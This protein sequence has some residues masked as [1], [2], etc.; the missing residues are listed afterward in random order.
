M[1]WA[2]TLISIQVNERVSNTVDELLRCVDG[3]LKVLIIWTAH[4]LHL[5]RVSTLNDALKL[6]LSIPLCSPVSRTLFSRA[7]IAISCFRACLINSIDDMDVCEIFTVTFFLSF[8]CFR[9]YFE[10]IRATAWWIHHLSTP[11]LDTKA[12][13]KK[14][15]I[16]MW[17]L[18]K[19]TN[20][21]SHM[22]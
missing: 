8:F 6:A 20:S 3:K 11:R 2:H 21:T 15:E 22:E 5:L 9:Q 16:K 13:W 12:R 14:S 1:G 10:L 19:R 4:T 17:K 18:H 7:R